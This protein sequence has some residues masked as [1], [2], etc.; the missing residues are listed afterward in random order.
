M[1][2]DKKKEAP[3]EGEEEKG[4][5]K[6]KIIL[7]AVLVLALAGGGWFMFL[8]PKS[9]AAA[10]PKPGIVAPLETITLN[11][12][13]GHFLQLRFALQATAS[14]AEAPDG[15]KAL[16]AAI[17]MFSDRKVAELSSKAA[18]EKLKKEFVKEVEHLYEG[19]VMN[20]YFTTFVMQ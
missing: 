7:I 18:R 10:E 20:V 1:A 19:E 17:E 5:G 6:K 16:D 12:D 14:V 3:A 11:L 2:K 9:A 15:S 13:G 4:G 8:K